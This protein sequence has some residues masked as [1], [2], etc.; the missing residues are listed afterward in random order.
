[1]SDDKNEVKKNVH[2]GHREKVKQR[3]YEVGLE[4]M[5]SHNILELLLFFGIPYKDTNPIAHDLIEHFGSLS[6]VLEAKR[7]DLL[8][9]KGMTDNIACLLTLILPLYRKYA[10]D[11]V[12]RCPKFSGIDETVDFLRALFLDSNNKERVYALCF[13]ANGYLIK[14]RMLS[15]GDIRSSAVDLRELAGFLLETNASSVLI[16]HNHPHGLASPSLDDINITKTLRDFL[17]ML[18]VKF[19]DHIIIGD[20]SYFSMVRSHRF[21]HIFYN[22]DPILG[23]ED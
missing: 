1:M 20:N 19:D 14:H 21:A 7:T 16:A 9:V 18:K 3:F 13:D 15:E 11:V 10:E 12:G 17:L 4:G 5:A 6:A 23:D 2:I 8:Q 22:I